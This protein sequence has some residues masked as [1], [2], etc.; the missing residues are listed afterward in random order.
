MNQT[1]FTY[2]DVPIS[3]VEAPARYSLVAFTGL[4][5]CGKT[6]AAH[7]LVSKGFVR[8]AFADPLKEMIGVLT[9][10]K[11]KT[12]CPEE[13]CGRSVREAYQLL[14][15]EWGRNMMGEDIW[16]RA[17][18]RR[19]AAHLRDVAAGLA[20]GV[21]IDDCRFDN[22]AELVR[23]LGGIVIRVER[24]GLVQMSHASEVGVDDMLVNYT[25]RNDD[26][27]QSLLDKVTALVYDPSP[28]QE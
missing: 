20:A 17:A 18:R 4:A 10:E 15:T 23:S 28:T 22:E 19:I 13:L 7:A 27:L 14:G 26:T 3:K 16:L 11:D 1:R 24:P 8:V 12:A 9:E 2:R 21:V 5:T 25:L 6:T